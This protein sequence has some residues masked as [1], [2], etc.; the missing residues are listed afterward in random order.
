MTIKVAA[1]VSVGPFLWILTEGFQKK[2][3]LNH[4]G[5]TIFAYHAVSGVC[6]GKKRT[7]LFGDTSASQPGGGTKSAHCILLPQANTMTCLLV[8][9]GG[10]DGGTVCKC[11]LKVPAAMSIVL[12]TVLERLDATH[13]T[14]LGGVHPGLG[15][16]G[17]ENWK[18]SVR[19][20][21]DLVTGL[22]RHELSQWGDALQQHRAEAEVARAEIMAKVCGLGKVEEIWGQTS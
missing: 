15:L 19:Q 5:V 11:H 22:L 14:P 21:L 10:D 8:S 6:V 16:A 7:N 18:P 9:V 20:D 2:T 4:R 3:H 13:N 17:F 1:V 12:S